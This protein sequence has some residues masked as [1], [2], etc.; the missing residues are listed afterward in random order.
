MKRILAVFVAGIV[1]CFGFTAFA[2][3]SEAPTVKGNIEIYGAAKMSVDMIDTGAKAQG[4][5]TSLQKVSSNS[6]R[7]GFKGKEDLGNGLSAVFQVELGVSMDESLSTSLRNTYVGLSS[8]SFGTV[9][10]GRH[11]T[12][13]KMVTG[14]FDA[15]GDT[16]ADYN[17]IIGNVNGSA[18]FDLRASNVAAYMTPVMA[19]FQVI[20]AE[21]V[22]ETTNTNIS[23]PSA[24][25]FAATY[26][27]GPLAV[28]AAHEIHKNGVTSWDDGTTITGTKLGAG[29]SFGETKLGFVY[30]TLK[31]DKANSPY[32]RNAV[33]L[34]VIQKLGKEKIKLAYGKADDGEDTNTKTGATFMAVGIDHEL[35]K[36]TTIYALY[37][38]TQNDK[39][40]TYGLGQSGAGGAYKPGADEDPSVI[41]FGIVHAF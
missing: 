3:D 17:S 12:P 26:K 16:M 39:N 11:D 38:A 20:A 14:Q 9:L 15:F 2:A 40:A 34:S 35:S 24:H 6:S 37:A 10:F 33:Y 31:D 29:Y 41:S 32:S 18:N 23:D 7:L 19:G 1:S 25:S 27:A 8:E 13:Y 36:R 21:V 22:S 4:A 5:D 28:V 30:E